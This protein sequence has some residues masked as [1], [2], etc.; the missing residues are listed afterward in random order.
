MV[1]VK[2]QAHA[3]SEKLEYG[4]A[5]IRNYSKQEILINTLKKLGLFWG[6][7]LFSLFL[8]VVHFFLV[9]LFLLL[10]VFFAFRARQF[11]ELI[12]FGEID[13]PNCNQKI[14][15]SSSAAN[16]PHTEI[17]QSCAIVI[18]INKM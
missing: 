14:K 3:N 18:K 7:A 15:I 1:Q 2:I 4:L 5:D 11:R 12:L 8:P 17:C 6:L 9:P 16:W 10:G 13:C